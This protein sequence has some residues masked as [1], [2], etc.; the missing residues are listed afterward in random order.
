MIRRAAALALLL[1][2]PP[3]HADAPAEPPGFRGAP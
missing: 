1:A 2:A 3:A